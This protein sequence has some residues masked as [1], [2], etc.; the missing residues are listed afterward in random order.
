MDTFIFIYA[1]ATV[2]YETCDEAFRLE[3]EDI[4]TP[5]TVPHFLF[6]DRTRPKNWICLQIGLKS[7][8]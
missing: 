5:C 2:F 4:Q 3:K 8:L 7:K 6:A 1:Y